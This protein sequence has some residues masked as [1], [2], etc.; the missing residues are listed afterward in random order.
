MYRK[1]W[2]FYQPT[3]YYK[4]YFKKG[5]NL[6]RTNYQFIFEN[7]NCRKRSLIVS[8]MLNKYVSTFQSVYKNIRRV[9]QQL[10]SRSQ[11]DFQAVVQNTGYHSY[12]SYFIIVIIIIIII[13]IHFLRHSRKLCFLQALFNHLIRKLNLCLL[14]IHDFVKETF[15]KQILCVNSCCGHFIIILQTRTTT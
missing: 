11:S 5:L 12:D 2:F 9:I 1:V 8:L 4:K 3:V 14:R 15:F 7:Q 13:I 6:T 10:L